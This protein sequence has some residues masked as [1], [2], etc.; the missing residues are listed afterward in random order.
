[1]YII[2][3]YELVLILNMRIV[4]LHTVICSPFECTNESSSFIKKSLIDH[5]YEEISLP[6]CLV[7]LLVVQNLTLSTLHNNNKLFV[8][9]QQPITIIVSLFFL[10]RMFLLYIDYQQTLQ[11]SS[12]SNNDKEEILIYPNETI[13]TRSVESNYNDSSSILN[14]NG[15]KNVWRIYD[16][17]YDVSDFIKYHPGGIESIMLGCNRPDC[18]SLIQSYHPFSINIVKTILKKYRINNTTTTS[19]EEDNKDTNNNNKVSTSTST[20]IGHENDLFYEVIIIYI[21]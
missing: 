12:N 4:F 1:M 13:S 21:L 3:H 18:T 9:L 11:V 20:N 2:L 19:N 8:L 16:N 14:K 5:V 7:L 17:E 6:I 10:Y 15:Q